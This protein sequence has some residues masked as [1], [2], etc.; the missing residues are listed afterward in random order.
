MQ[1]RNQQSSHPQTPL[2]KCFHNTALLR[3]KEEGM[4]YL[5]DSDP[6]ATLAP[7]QQAPA[8]T[9]LRSGRERGKGS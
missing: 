5:G 7:L 8:P 6:E 3:F 1:L 4:T 2:K 9:A